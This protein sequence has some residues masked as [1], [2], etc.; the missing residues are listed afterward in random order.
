MLQLD[1]RQWRCPQPVV[2][3]RRLLLAEPGQAL[4]VFL[5]DETARSNVRRL[6][7]KLGY[8]AS[9]APAE[10]GFTLIL[11]PAEAVT[12][13]ASAAAAGPTVVLIGSDRMGEG[14]DELGRVL[15][16]NFLIT[17]A[18]LDQVPD[19][20]YFVNAGVKLAVAGSESV[21]VLEKLVCAGSDIASCGLCLDYF[22]LKEQV[23][24]GRVT[25]MLDIATA[26]SG[27]GRIIRP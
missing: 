20:L 26:L 21:E 17:L 12:A 13:A 23:A 10:D 18:E 2:E 15:L 1:C 7:G 5:A 6:A 24:V 14:S 22:G 16:R 3:V 25:N 11:S 8:A 9:D 27:A 4:T 19:V